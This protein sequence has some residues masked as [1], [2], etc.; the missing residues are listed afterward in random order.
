MKKLVLENATCA[1]CSS[2]E[3]R[4]VCSGLCLKLYDFLLDSHFFHFKIHSGGMH[5]SL[6]IAKVGR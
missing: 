5:P 1:L 3:E 2:Q 4:V 6:M